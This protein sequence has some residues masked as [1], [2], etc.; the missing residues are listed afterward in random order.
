MA[1]VTLKPVTPGQR[2][3]IRIVTPELHK[4][5]P[6]KSLL[7]AK[8]RTSGRNN[9]GRMTVAHR[10]GGHKRHI[11]VIDWQRTKD[12]IPAKVV[13]IEYDPNRTAHIALVLYADGEY[14][15]ILAPKHLK[16]GDAIMSGAKATIEVGNCLPMNSMPIGSTIHG[17][18]MKVGKGAQLARSAGAF[19]QLMA[20]HE[21]YA[22]LKL[23]S[24]VIYRVP[25]GCRAT[26]GE[27]SNGDHNLQNL[28]KAGRSR[29]MGIRPT[30]RGVAKNPVDH[31]LGGGE[32]KTSGGRHPCNKNGLVDGKKTRNNRRTN[33]FIMKGRTRNKSV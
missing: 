32:G 19:V 9:Q 10:G 29:N 27:V 17:I 4:G 28:G 1:I 26:I 12:D 21:G 13:R 31:P 20:R 24:G 33:R 11:R 16:A 7:V 14:R 18:E 15:Y 5:R 22:I 2:G 30:V 23:R 3:R 25:E 6:M 8:K